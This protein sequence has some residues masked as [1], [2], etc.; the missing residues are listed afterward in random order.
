[1]SKITQWYIECKTKE[2]FELLEKVVHR[3]GFAYYFPPDQ[4]KLPKTL[5][6]IEACL[7]NK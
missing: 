7:E 5:E 6:E 4:D 1:M 2:D 3:L